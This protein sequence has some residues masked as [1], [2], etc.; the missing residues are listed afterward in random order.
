[1]RRF[2]QI[3]PLV[4]GA[5]VVVLFVLWL[6]RPIWH[7][8]A[9]FLWTAPFVWIMPLALLGAGAVLLRRSQRSWATLEDL[10]TGVRPPAG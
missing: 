1:M 10:R 3:N 4:I 5:V 6:V 7:G 8:F 9:L 2:K